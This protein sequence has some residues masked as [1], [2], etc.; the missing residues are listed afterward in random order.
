[1]NVPVLKYNWHQNKE[2]NKEEKKSLT[3]SPFTINDLDWNLKYNLRQMWKF[4][5]HKQKSKNKN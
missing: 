1:M 2:P 5:S 3:K 4:D